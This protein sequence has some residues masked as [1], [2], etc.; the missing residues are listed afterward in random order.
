MYPRE[1][2]IEQ[3][4]RRYAPSSGVFELVWTHC[5]I[6]KEITDMIIREKGLAVDLELVTAGALLHDIG[7]YPLISSSGVFNRPQYIRHGIEGYLILKKEQ[8]PEE[9]CRMTTHHTGVGIT[10]EEVIAQK[11]PIPPVDYLA[12]TLEEKLIMYA[13]KFH[14]KTPQFNTLDSYRQS[15]RK[16]GEDKVQKLAELTELFGIPDLEL[17]ARKYNHPVR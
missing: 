17:L 3:L 4:H 9:L 2:E 6:I 13:D 14:S 12:E 11:L 8:L 7:A 15:V 1:K 16:Y 10:K 5:Q